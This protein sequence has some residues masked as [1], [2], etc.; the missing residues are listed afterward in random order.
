MAKYLGLGGESSYYPH[1]IIVLTDLHKTLIR[2][3]IF[4]PIK[5]SRITGVVT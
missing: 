2:W 4:L 1:T 5:T 3:T